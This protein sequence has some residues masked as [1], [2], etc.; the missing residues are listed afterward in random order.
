MAKLKAPLFSFS[1]RRRLGDDVVFQRRGRVN[2]AGARQTHPDARSAGQLSWRHMFQKVVALWHALSLAEQA[3][4]ESAAR[5][6]H[7][8]GYAWFVS[9]ALRPNP[10]IYLPLQGGIMQ[11]DIDTAGF[12]VENLP[13]PID[14]Q[15]PVTKNYFENNLP[16]SSR[17][18]WKDTSQTALSDL[19]RTV[20][21]GMTDLDLT[22]YT[23]ADAKIALLLLE[24]RADVIGSGNSCLL[25]LRKNSTSPP[26]RPSLQ[27]DKAAVT[28]AVYQF[29]MVLVGL[30]TSQ[31]LEY[32]I[33]VGTGWQID[34]RIRVLGY[35][36]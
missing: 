34:S 8:S 20:S 19:N 30:D 18:V 6:K 3:A 32:L 5:S 28:V 17:F 15:E 2:I 31:I 24:M 10:G 25:A 22:A 36:E 26:H 7:M 27:L 14:A 16:L 29:A 1:A 13:D 12:K 33:T 11:G 35:V 9:Q 4:W 23:S 21:Q